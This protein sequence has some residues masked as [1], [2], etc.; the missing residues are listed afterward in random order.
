MCLSMQ[1]IHSDLPIINLVYVRMR[2]LPVALNVMTM[3]GVIVECM[4]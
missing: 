4:E 2:V 3:C 1:S